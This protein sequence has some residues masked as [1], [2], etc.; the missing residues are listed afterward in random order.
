MAEFFTFMNPIH[1]S[2]MDGSRML[3][4]C[5][6][7]KGFKPEE[8]KVEINTKERVITVTATHDVKDKDHSVTRNYVRKFVIPSEYLVD[9]SKCEIK[10]HL[11]FDSLLCIEGCLP[12]M[13]AEEL[14]TIKEK[15]PSKLANNCSAFCPAGFSNFESMYGCTIPVKTI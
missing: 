5:F 3:Y 10:S 13:T 7:V 15:C 14:K 4:L 12:K 1:I 2:P 9:L 6:D 8:I 11:T